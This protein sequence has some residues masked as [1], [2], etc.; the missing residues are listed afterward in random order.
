MNINTG[1]A[2]RE[3]FAE[4]E[5][6]AGLP[7][8]M[9][10]GIAIA[11]G[12]ILLIGAL[13]FMAMRQQVQS[14]ERTLHTLD[15][16]ASVNAVLSMV[17]D[18]E[19]GQRGFILTGREEYLQPYVTADSDLPAELDSLRAMVADNP[20][21]QR[22]EA[23]L[24]QLAMQ[25]LE[26]L[27]Q[28]VELRRTQGAIDALVVVNSDRGKA[29]MDQI[30][31]TSHAMLLEEQ[32]LLAARTE[33]LQSAQSR[34]FTVII[35]GLTTLLL[36]VLVA[37]NMAARETRNKETEGW[38]RAGVAALVATM[39]GEHRLHAL[40]DLVLRF[41]TRQLRAPAGAF[42]VVE[43]G[44]TLRRAAGFAL[45]SDAPETYALGEGLVGEAARSGQLVEVRDVPAQHLRFE[46]TLLSTPP[47]HL[48][49][50]PVAY[51]GR[52]NAV[53]ELALSRAPDAAQV[54][55][56]ERIRAALG[57]AVNSSIDRS[58]LEELL[59][60]TQ[61]QSEELQTQQEEL[62]VANEE[63]QEQSQALQESQARLEQQQAELE[64][65]NSHLEE[66]TRALEEH[67]DRQARDEVELRERSEALQRANEYK[68]EFLANMSHELRTPL[69]SSLILAKLLS[70]NREG[71][72]SEEQVRFAQTIHSAGNDLLALINDI[73]D[74]SKIEA[75]KM[76]IEVERLELS[77]LLDTLQQGFT[78]V[79]REK[80]LRF[81]VV[82]SPEVPSSIQSDGQRVLQVLRN[83][84]S[85]AFKFT[86]T[87][88]V[89]VRVTA[90]VSPQG[91]R[92]GFA[93]RDT[94][95]GIDPSQQQNI[96]EAFRQADGS[97]HRKYG[98]TGLGLSI[99]RDLAHLLGGEVT[100]ESVPGS[101]STFTFWLPET[102]P[103]KVE[104]AAAL[105]APLP[106]PEAPWRTVAPPTVS[107]PRAAPAGKM[108][109]ADAVAQAKTFT[110]SDS[111]RLLAPN[112]RVLL[113]IDDDI[114]FAAILRDMAVEQGFE[115]IVTHTAA[116]GLAAARSYHISAILL[117]MHLPDRTGLA[118]LDEL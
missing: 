14:R 104:G 29:L 35:G 30:R 118:V 27:K 92:V 73:L 37:G 55:L 2:A 21:Q 102:P 31:E 113:V 105:H 81:E 99:S 48:V 109:L 40:G 51:G 22:R 12:A 42:Y 44:R 76:D 46:S 74:L 53:L 10:V 89:S 3:D 68:S 38:L 5:L 94:G 77:R 15:V 57:I 103:A 107:A 93:V 47:R 26:E 52:V 41:L 83:L 67:A 18:A 56:L 91:R 60:E 98:G 62:R 13:A 58:R 7:P 45:V 69:N 11:I 43:Q 25:K 90:A 16:L 78:E 88:E 71:N 19:T 106:A 66:Q 17:K 34:S 9:V 4:I 84:L 82:Q 54:Q 20:E 86:A 97:T 36:L 75:G 6:K 59:E 61:R 115:A 101:G 70:D 96:F 8:R 110:A 49:L 79:A 95:I 72:L 111:G 87:G 28:T 64:Q 65:T 117:D 85:N 108:A 100:V 23:T 39:Q 1:T 24:R 33:A 112:A 32:G 80:G 114:A 63:L 116:E 50:I